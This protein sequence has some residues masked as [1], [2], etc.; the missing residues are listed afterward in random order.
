MKEM[1]SRSI[2]YDYDAAEKSIE[3]AFISFLSRD[4][5]RIAAIVLHN[6]KKYNDMRQALRFYL[7]FGI[8]PS[9]D[10]LGL[11][12]SDFLNFEFICSL[13]NAASFCIDNMEPIWKVLNDRYINFGFSEAFCNFVCTGNI[14]YYTCFP[15][16]ILAKDFRILFG[17]DKS[18][19]VDALAN[20]R[21]M[22][23]SGKYE[24]I[25]CYFLQKECPWLCSNENFHYDYHGGTFV[26]CENKGYTT[27]SDY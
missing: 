4:A 3:H 23:D 14:D 8:D 18:Q 1:D 21:H 27:D 2:V 20:A 22:T 25:L 5:A 10:V 24:S 17:I 11:L 6:A 26:L 15:I 12:L 13:I 19:F 9:R 16:D 7:A